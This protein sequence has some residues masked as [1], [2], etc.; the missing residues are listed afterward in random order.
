MTLEARTNEVTYPQR[1]TWVTTDTRLVLKSEDY[2]ANGRLM[3]T[4]LIPSYARVDDKYIAT[5]I[6]FVDNLIEGKKTQITFTDISFAPL[7]DSVFTKAYV[8]RVNR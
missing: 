3:R 7:A 2:S 4:S 8:E 1:R 5:R 6:I